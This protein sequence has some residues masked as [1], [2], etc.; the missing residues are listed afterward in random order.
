MSTS[1]I[2]AAGV[3]ALIVLG[4]IALLSLVSGRP[5]MLGS[6]PFSATHAQELA[7]VFW[8]AFGPLPSVQITNCNSNLN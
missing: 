4:I 7:T 5:Y 8:T 6:V 3:I 2:I 1:A